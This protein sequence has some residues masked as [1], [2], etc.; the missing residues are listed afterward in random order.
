MKIYHQSNIYEQI[1]GGTIKFEFELAYKLKMAAQRETLCIL[2]VYVLHCQV[3]MN[4][5]FFGNLG[6]SFV[7]ERL[8]EETQQLI[9]SF[10]FEPMGTTSAR[11]S[12]AS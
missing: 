4:H 5:A 10:M 3:C 9:N 12:I 2:R 6:A 1:L 8:P 11:E 7:F